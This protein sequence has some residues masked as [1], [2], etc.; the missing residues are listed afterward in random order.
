MDLRK[1]TSL[2]SERLLV[3]C[4]SGYHSDQSAH[5]QRLAGHN[6]CLPVH[7]THTDRS[8]LVIVSD[9]S[10][11]LLSSDQVG[12]NEILCKRLGTSEHTIT[13]LKGE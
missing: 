3:I 2:L 9:I 13:V 4:S 1:C 10:L 5:P 7:K 12:L 8:A 11:S 6:L